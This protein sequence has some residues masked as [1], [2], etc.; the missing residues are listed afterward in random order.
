MEMTFRGGRLPRLLYT[1]HQ[2][3]GSFELIRP[4]H[5]HASSTELLYVG[6]GLG[7]YIVNDTSYEIV[8]GDILLYNQGDQHELFSPSG[9]ALDAYCF[10]LTDLS[11]TGL[12]DGHLNRL[13]GGFVRTAGEKS[14]EIASL[15][16]LIY[17]GTSRN[18]PAAREITGHLLAA[19]VLLAVDLPVTDRQIVPTADVTLANR[20]RT[21]IGQHFC[22]PLT[23][24]GIGDALGVSPYHAA[25]VFKEVTGTSPI[26]Y[27]I[28]C[29]VGEAETLLIASALSAVQIAEMVGYSSVSHFNT[30]FTKV[31][32]MSPIRYRKAYLNDLRGQ[33]T[34]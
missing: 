24:Q 18:D 17:E 34:Q 16:R 32:G 2:T 26:Q 7:E 28:R 31:V 15:C 30:V 33:R 6:M 13:P 3:Y 25:H 9:R 23:L 8:P 19:L 21:Y 14:R 1:N 20:I 5:R 27:M 12:P 22:E 11:L 29:R 10:G 4:I